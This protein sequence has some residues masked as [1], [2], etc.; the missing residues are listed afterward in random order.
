MMKERRIKFA[1]ADVQ[2]KP[3]PFCG[4]GVHMIDLGTSFALDHDDGDRECFNFLEF[5]K[6]IFK[7][8]ETARDAWNRRANDEEEGNW[9]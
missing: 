8:D 7:T 9:A 6:I 1:R 3:C 5:R 2:L 4:K